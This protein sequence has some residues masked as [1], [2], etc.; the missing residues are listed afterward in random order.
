MYPCIRQPIAF[1]DYAN[2]L[3]TSL[4]LPRVEGVLGGELPP[5]LHGQRDV[6][7]DD[8]RHDQPVDTWG[9]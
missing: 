9:G 6:P 5:G 4:S 7:R 3:H 2:T 1:I 8:H